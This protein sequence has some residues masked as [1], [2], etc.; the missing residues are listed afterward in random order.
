ML[1]YINYQIL[2]YNRE[3]Y[4]MFVIDGSGIKWI[5]WMEQTFWNLEMKKKN[6][7]TIANLEK[8]MFI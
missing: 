4:W 8:E 3:F 5:K 2:F 1:V 7:F 6:K